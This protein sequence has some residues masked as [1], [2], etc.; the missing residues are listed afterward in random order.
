MAKHIFHFTSYDF[1]RFKKGKCWSTEKLNYS[2]YSKDPS[3]KIELSSDT[4]LHERA[5][6]YN[7][8]PN[9]ELKIPHLDYRQYPHGEPYRG[10]KEGPG[11][12]HA[13][14]IHKCYLE[15]HAPSSN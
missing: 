1:R 14:R 10:P 9:S 4:G 11:H 5:C 8:E 6:S 15:N 12:F 13:D 3:N 2:D 7:S